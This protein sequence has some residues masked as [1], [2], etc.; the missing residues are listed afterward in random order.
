M[1]AR[2]GCARGA[3]LGPRGGGEFA[4]QPMLAF[5]RGLRIISALLG[6]GSSKLRTASRRA[7]QALN[8]ARSTPSRL[9]IKATGIRAISSSASSS[10]WAVVGVNGISYLWRQARPGAPLPPLAWLG[11]RHGAYAGTEALTW[12]APDQ[13]LRLVDSRRGSGQPQY[14]RRLRRSVG[15]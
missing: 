2:F 1:S 6:G 8:V 9:A 14:S 4:A 15:T 3:F 13:G 5:K 12:W 11:L 10:N 7:V